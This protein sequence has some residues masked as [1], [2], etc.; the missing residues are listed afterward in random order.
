MPAALLALVTGGSPARAAV[1]DL[2]T[3]SLTGTVRVPLLP[4]MGA[5]VVA[6]AV[7][8]LTARLAALWE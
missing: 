2:V 6:V 8:A 7:A 1:T 3:G 4:A 5:A